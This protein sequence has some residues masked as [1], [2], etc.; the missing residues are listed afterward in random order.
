MFFVV[1]VHANDSD[2]INYVIWTGCILFI[3]LIVVSSS[4]CYILNKN[5]LLKHSAN[6][7]SALEKRTV[8]AVGNRSQNVPGS[9]DRINEQ[10]M[11]PDHEIEIQVVTKEAVGKNSNED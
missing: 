7:E 11:C 1:D 2:Y 10:T 8:A 3:I 5:L 9:C 6:V 4:I